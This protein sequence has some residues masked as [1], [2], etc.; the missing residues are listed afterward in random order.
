MAFDS[1]RG[2]ETHR[3]ELHRQPSG[4]ASR[5]SASSA[6]K[7]TAARC[8]TRC[9]ATPPTGPRASVATAR[10]EAHREEL[11]H[12]P[13]R[14]LDPLGRLRPP[15]RGSRSVSSPRAP[16]GS[17]STSW[18][19]TTCPNLTIGPTVAAALK[20]Y[21]GRPTGRPC[22][23]RRAPDGA[24]GRRAG[25]A[26]RRGR[27]RPHQ[28][29]PGGLAARRSHAAAD[30]GGRLPGRARLQPGDAA[31]RARVR[32]RQ[33][34]P[35]PR[36]EREPGLRRAEL[37]RL[38]A[39]QDRARPPLHRRLRARHPSRGRRRHQGRQHPARRGRGRRHL[40][41]RQRDLRLRRLPGGD[42]RDALRAARRSAP[43]A[44]SP[45]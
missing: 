16:T 20:P 39:A 6:R 3:D 40:R 33:G 42:R 17:T 34:R 43:S 5:A 25:R 24:A 15:R 36:H 37:H 35:R 41:R 7:A 22:A 9:A 18:T 27:R 29:P 30:P 10:P 12:A 13:D 8:A 2:I 11:R 23:A 21:L 19:I 44:R 4:A 14:A 45:E 31:R 26:L 1:T 28:L 32:D 38:G